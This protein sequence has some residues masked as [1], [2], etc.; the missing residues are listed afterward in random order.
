MLMFQPAPVAPQL[1]PSGFDVQ[2]GSSPTGPWNP[3]V[4]LVTKQPTRAWCDALSPSLGAGDCY[5][6]Q[7]TVG[8]TDTHLRAS[9]YAM[10]DSVKHGS[11]WSNVHTVPET[12]VGALFFLFVLLV[13][14][15]AG[16]TP[17]RPP[18]VTMFYPRGPLGPHRRD[19]RGSHSLRG[20]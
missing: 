5:L 20:K 6:V 11:G 7:T 2:S 15:V 12:N 14:A 8:P 16:D 17:R 18:G 3:A 10:V 9:A 13:M 4:A 1:P 19:R